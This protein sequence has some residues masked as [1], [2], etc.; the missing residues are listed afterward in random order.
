MGEGRGAVLMLEDAYN[1]G[2]IAIRSSYNILTFST[3]R[4][5]CESGN[6]NQP[7][8]AKLPSRKLSKMNSIQYGRLFL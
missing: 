3:A 7:I 8:L 5:I 4:T 2:F 6:Q 1:I